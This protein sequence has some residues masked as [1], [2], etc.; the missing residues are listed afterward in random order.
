MIAGVT[1]G[2]LK[3]K[4]RLADRRI[5]CATP[6]TNRRFASFPSLVFV[7]GRPHS[8]CGGGSRDPLGLARWRVAREW[9]RTGDEE[10]KFLEAAHRNRGRRP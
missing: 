1:N 4:L 8:S 3:K 9:V 7:S 5:A 6:P 10:E 2:P